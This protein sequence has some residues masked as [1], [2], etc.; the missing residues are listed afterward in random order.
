MPIRRQHPSSRPNIGDLVR[1]VGV[2]CGCQDHHTTRCEL[3]QWVGTTARITLI[4]R[5]RHG[6][7]FE[8]FGLDGIPDRWFEDELRVIER[9]TL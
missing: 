1:I 6:S 9:A 2:G 7:V 3:H 5:P 4:T 8:Q